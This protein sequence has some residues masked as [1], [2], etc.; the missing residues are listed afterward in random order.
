[1]PED[2]PFQESQSE[3]RRHRRRIR[4]LTHKR[5][6]RQPMV[7]SRWWSRV[8]WVLLWVGVVVLLIFVHLYLLD[9]LSRPAP[10]PQ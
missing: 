6:R 2:S 4:V 8:L 1:M 3:R 10:V 7:S 9:R 5:R